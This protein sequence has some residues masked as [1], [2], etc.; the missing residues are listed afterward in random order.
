ML[1]HH[2]KQALRSES[3]CMQVL[4]AKPHMMYAWP[5]PNESQQ[6]VQHHG[7]VVSDYLRACKDECPLHVP[8]MHIPYAAIAPSYDTPTQLGR[9]APRQEPA[10]GGTQLLAAARAHLS[11]AIAQADIIICGDALPTLPPLQLPLLVV[12]LPRAACR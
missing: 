11:K 6:M 1:C 10:G 7:A 3:I 2:V 12:V 8:C 4:A 5:P 9:C